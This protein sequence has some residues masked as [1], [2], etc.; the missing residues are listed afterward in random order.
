MI[1]LLPNVTNKHIYDIQCLKHCE[2]VSEP[3]RPKRTIPQCAN[4]DTL[5]PIVTVFQNEPNV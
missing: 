2:V 3:T 4:M 5:E 1:E